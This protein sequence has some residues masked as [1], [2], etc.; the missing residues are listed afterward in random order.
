MEHAISCLSAHGRF[1]FITP[2]KF[3]T[4]QTSAPLRR[5][6]E[7]EGSVRTVARFR[8]HKVFADA[9]TVPCVT[10]F[11]RT[12]SPM[13]TTVLEC[14][15][16]PRSGRVCV[17]RRSYAN[18]SVLRQGEWRFD[19]PHLRRL[20]AAIQAMHPPL[21]RFVSRHSAGTAS[22]CDAVFVLSAAAA[23]SVESDLLRP[24]ARGRDVL[25][26]GIDNSGLALLVPYSFNA[27]SRPALVDLRKHPGVA[28]YLRANE[29]ALRN[30]HCVRVWEKAWFDLHDPIP[31]DIGRLPKIL[32]P[33]VASH[34]RFAYD[35][36]RYW[37]LHSAYYML[38]E[39]IDPVFLTAVL[40]S[41]P[42]EF[43]I[44]LRAPVVK[45]GFSRYRK[46]FLGPLPVPQASAQ[47]RMQIVRAVDEG[48][49]GRANE[50]VTGLFRLSSAELR[51]VHRYLTEAAERRPPA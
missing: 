31:V 19:A 33:D 23:G 6:L 35:R 50:L 37:P 20:A 5:L 27:D 41:T 21:S 1:A 22:G 30:R 7:R 2:D 9:A 26:F 15:D 18:A 39:H 16:R 8:S 46:Q 51:H 32:V 42:I 4:S 28:A 13:R 49:Y 25:S 43:L 29:E 40:N 48:D 11:E 44:R 36:G 12:K 45:D 14:D 24:A 10:V 34:N 47:Q 17:R 38:P 3:L